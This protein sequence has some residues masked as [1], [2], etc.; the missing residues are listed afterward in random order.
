MIH[1]LTGETMKVFVE[2][3]LH[4]LESWKED[5]ATFM[6]QWN[7]VAKISAEVGRSRAMH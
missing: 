4:R 2:M 1:T 5:Q 6:N 7:A 3:L